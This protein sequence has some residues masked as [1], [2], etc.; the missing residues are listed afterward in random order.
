MVAMI[1]MAVGYVM[2]FLPKSLNSG[3]VRG[4]A[5]LGFVGEWVIVVAAI[6]LVMQ[7]DALLAMSVGGGDGLPMYAAF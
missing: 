1:M 6:W 4:I 3:A 7:C 5:R 2:H